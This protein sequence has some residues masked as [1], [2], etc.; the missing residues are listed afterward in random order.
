VI[1]TEIVSLPSEGRFYTPDHPLRKC[2]VKVR[3]ITGLDEQIMCHSNILNK[4]LLERWIIDNLVVEP[5]VPIDGWLAMDVEA[6]LLNIRIM[7]YGRVFKI[8]WTCGRCDNVNKAEIDLGSFPQNPLIPSLTEDKLLCVHPIEDRFLLF[9][10]PTWKEKKDSGDS[11]VELLKRVLIEKDGNASFLSVQDIENLP[12]K[13]ARSIRKLFDKGIPRF[14][15]TI[16][17]KCASC[18][19][20]VKTPL[21]IDQTIFGYDSKTKADI[22][23][24]MFELCYYSNGG[25]SIDEVEKMETT[26]RAF[27]YGKL[28][29]AK[30]KE[31]DASKGNEQTPAPKIAKPPVVK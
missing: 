28:A 4:G 1:F 23:T 7:N 3:L 17:V 25:F 14:D 22:L 31:E 29:D 18:D 12:A 26:K 13:Q 21:G 11:I 24:Q 15:N 16:N 20:D 10:P 19:S 30:K 8:S 5:K 27:F 9:R 2:E 6:L